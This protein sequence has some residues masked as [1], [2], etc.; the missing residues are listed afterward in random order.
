MKDHP[1]DVRSTAVGAGTGEIRVGKRTPKKDMS[2]KVGGFRAIGLT[3]V[4]QGQ[5]F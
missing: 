5:G 4:E 3:S 1:G 2:N